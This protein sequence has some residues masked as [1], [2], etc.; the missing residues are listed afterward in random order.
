MNLLSLFNGIS[1]AQLA[2]ERAGIKTTCYASEIDKYANQI[3]LKNYPNT[4]M[5]GDVLKW[6]SWDLPKID[7]M[8]WGSPCQDL[9]IAG[10]QK[11]LGGERSSLFW[12]SLEIFRK[13]KPKYWI[14]ENVASMKKEDREMISFQLGV[15]PVE[16]NSA[17]VS[18][19]SRKRLY[20]T[21]L[22]IDQPKDLK[23]TLQNI[24]DYGITE[25]DKSYCLD[26]SYH[27]GT[28]SLQYL[29]NSRQQVVFNK[30]LQIGF[31]GKNRMAE[32]IYRIEGKSVCL[33]ANGGGLGAKTGLYK[34][35]L[36]NGD[37]YVRK[38]SPI[39][40]E[41]LQTFPDN[42]T[43]GCSNT[44]RYKMLG[45]SFTVDV[46]AHILRCVPTEILLELYSKMVVK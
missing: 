12:E 34:I 10:K 18:A 22:K 44:Q 46:V 40:C 38:L 1:G 20:W 25:K 5:M 43:E 42:W 19:Q 26:A 2:C 11:G 45:N 33:K 35:D 39:E 29:T 41:R 27:K 4:I 8:V 13:A 14:M 28:N 30:P 36:P 9:S 37:F 24:L 3:T 21:N 32:R 7:I 23:I 17:L 15:Q 16:I 6:K 31:I